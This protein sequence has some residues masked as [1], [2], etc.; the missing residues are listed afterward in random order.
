MN[1]PTLKELPPPPS[2]RKGWPWTE[3]TMQ[4]PDTMSNG[5]PWPCISIVTPVYNQGQFLEET[6]RSVLLQGYPNLEYII[7]DGGSTDGSVEII[8]K[9]ETWLTY[10]ESK[11]D[12]GQSHAINKGISLSTGDFIAWINSDDYYFPVTFNKI[13]KSIAIN[14]CD[15]LLGSVEVIDEK[16]LRIKNYPAI[17]EPNN[18]K[19][20]L[21]KNDVC[22]FPYNQSSMFASRKMWHDVGLLNENLHYGMV[23]EWY[24]RALQK[25]YRPKLIPAFLSKARFHEDAK[26]IAYPWKFSL[27]YSKIILKMAIQRKFRFFP[28]LKVFLNLLGKGNRGKSDYLYISGRKYRSLIPCLKS[29]LASV[30]LGNVKGKSHLSRIK[31]VFKS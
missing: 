14:E 10:W 19:N 26:T 9:Y 18:N 31:R 5:L 12:R 28:S 25:G 17:N 2:G 7:I 21:F 22:L 23:G 8:K 30:L 24:F 29:L 3:E 13:I 20:A 15:W 1:R 4:M 27:E 6:I 11:K 16:G